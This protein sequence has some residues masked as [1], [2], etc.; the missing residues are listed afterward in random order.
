[1]APRAQDPREQVRG[2]LGQQR[3]IDV[4][5]GH[6]RMLVELRPG[7]GTHA[8]E[9][10]NRVAGPEAGPHQ[11]IFWLITERVHDPSGDFSRPARR[12]VAGAIRVERRADILEAHFYWTGETPR[13]APADLGIT[14]WRGGAAPGPL[15]PP[16]SEPSDRG[17]RPARGPGRRPRPR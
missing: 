8:S 11:S 9:L 14:R 16:D 1:Q 13:I 7:H 17:S 10:S 4:D 15:I 12:R 5:E 6:R 3:A 2:R